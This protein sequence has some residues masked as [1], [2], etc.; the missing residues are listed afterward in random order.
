MRFRILTFDKIDSTQTYA[1]SLAKEGIAEGT[2]VISDY[3]TK[4]RG[5]FRRRWQ[6]PR[7]KNLLFSIILRPSRK[8]YKTPLITHLAA[9]TVK[10]TLEAYS[11]VVC[12]LKKPNDVLMRGKKVSGILTESHSKAHTIDYL[13]VGIG[14]NINS[15][16]KNLVRGATSLFKETQTIYSRELVFNTFL[17][18]FATNYRS[19][20]HRK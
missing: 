4:G 18:K 17:R 16:P 8:I 11:N 19:F 14:I 9:Q 12:T 3:Q 10:E 5:R 15:P 2:V 13:I 6:S 7:G 1:L 20:L